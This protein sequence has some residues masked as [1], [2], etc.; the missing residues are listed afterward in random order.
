[1]NKCQFK[2]LS[3]RKVVLKMDENKEDLRG[4]IPAGLL[5]GC[6]NSYISILI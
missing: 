5:K 6:V 2:F 4:D 3:V 1:M